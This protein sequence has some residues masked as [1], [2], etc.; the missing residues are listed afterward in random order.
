MNGLIPS[1]VHP[2]R[3][4]CEISEGEHLERRDF[5]HW[6]EMGS[7]PSNL[8]NRLF[9]VFNVTSPDQEVKGR[10][11]LPGNM[12]PVWYSYIFLVFFFCRSVVLMTD[13]RGST[14]SVFIPRIFPAG[15]G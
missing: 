6:L 2:V 10:T 13:G 8:E 15:R 9:V 4:A 14:R 1:I 12:I 3:Q 11:A 7:K 5:E